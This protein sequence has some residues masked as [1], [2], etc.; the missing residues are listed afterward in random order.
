MC[1]L[2]I[3]DITGKSIAEARAWIGAIGGNS[4]QSSVISYQNPHPSLPSEGEGTN[5]NLPTANLGINGAVK[6]TAKG[7]KRKSRASR[8]GRVKVEHPSVLSDR[9][10]AIAEQILKE[11]EARLDF[12]LNV[13]LDYLTLSRTASTLSGGEGAAH[14]TGDADRV[15]AYGRAVCVRRA[16]RL[17]C[18]RRTITG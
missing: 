13:G 5:G 18:I 12:L 11:I 10:K 16:L 6:K 4:S 7:R 14:T 3:M 8:N 17:G 15:G 9:E 2:N 1:G